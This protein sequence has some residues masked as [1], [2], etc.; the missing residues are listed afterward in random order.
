MKFSSTS[1]PDK[2]TDCDISEWVVGECSVPCDDTCPQPDPYQCGGWQSLTREPIV[3][4]N[5]FGIKC[6]PLTN[7]KKCNQIKCPVDCVMSMWSSWSK[8]TKEC[9]GGVQGRTRSILTKPKNGG[10]SCNTVSESEPCNTGSCDRN[11]KLKKWSKW[12]PCSVACGG[13]FQERW[14]RVSIPIRGNGKCPKSKSKIRYGIKKCN[15]FDCNGDEICIAK[16]DL[17]MA[18]DASG[19]LRENGF[20][21]VQKFATKLIEKYKGEYYGYED[22]R[23]GV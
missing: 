16:Q 8:C 13:G 22:M 2:I 3:P 20:K 21:V 11:C 5:E 1:T 9:E 19:S 6:P 15:S 12:S 17:V 23:V 4:P 14:R 7:K 18:I 10:M